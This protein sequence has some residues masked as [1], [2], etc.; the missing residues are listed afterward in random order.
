LARKSAASPP[1]KPTRDD[2]L[3]YIRSRTERVTVSDLARHFNV[4]GKDRSALRATLRDAAAEG[5]IAAG[6]RRKYFSDESLPKVGVLEVTGPDSDGELLA[7]PVHWPADK[8]APVIYVAPLRGQP[9]ALAAGERILAR[10]T[11]DADG[12]YDATVMRRLGTAPVE[13]IGVF[14]REGGRGRIRPTDRRAKYDY[15]VEAR[16]DRGAEPGD[17]VRARVLPQRSGSLRMVEVIERVGKLDSPGAIGLIALHSNDIPIAF[18]PAALDEAAGARPPTLDGREDLREVALVTIDDE[19]ARDFDDAVFAE[20]DDAPGNAGGHRIIVAIADVAW[21]VRPG[22]AL[23]RA[24]ERRGNSVYLPDRVVPMLP[25]ALSNGLCSLRPHEDRAV[26]ACHMRIAADG[27]ILDHRFSRAL[28]RSSARLTYRRV[29][30]ARDGDTDALPDGLEPAA[31]E[32]LY[33]A[34]TC[35]EKARRRRGTLELELP[36]Y[37]VTIDNGKVTDIGLRTRL[38]SHRLIEEFMIAANVAAAEALEAKRA[39]CMYRVHPPPDAAKLEALRDFLDTF[40]LSLPRG[41]VTRAGQFA[42]ILSRASAGPS[43][44]VIHEA[45]LR[46]Q[47]QAAYGPRNFGHF[48]L[49]L[50][51]YAHFTSPIRRYADLMVHRALI[52]AWQLGPGGTGRDADVDYDEV[53]LHISATERKAQAAEREAVDRYMALYLSER[54]GTRMKGRI[55][56]VTR[57]GLF[58]RLKGLGADGLVPMGLLG[59]ERFRHDERRHC[60]EGQVSGRTFSLGDEV[61]VD[62]REATP[63]TGGLVLAITRHWPLARPAQGNGRA[64]R[65]GSRRRPAVRAGQHGKRRRKH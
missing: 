6:G 21:Y 16:H 4:K 50:R 15:G 48:G 24:A 43:A 55:T 40:G 27:N 5:L 12:G 57:F 35:L 38:D 64:D 46:A 25:E 54:T 41:Q 10:I 60:I 3:A 18:P 13:I 11:P 20:P 53:G 63:L 2:I 59:D 23:D 7:R 32:N 65:G 8:P 30:R 52:A 61:E 44:D 26:L 37:K 42:D 51:R 29:Q 14:E 39:P 28:M 17:L 31:I 45:I 34:F 22:S 33:A 47:S 49:A 58:V 62:I 9:H 19:D 36:E 1:G 56:G